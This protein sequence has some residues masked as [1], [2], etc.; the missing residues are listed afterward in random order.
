MYFKK[1]ITFSIYF[2]AIFTIA[3]LIFIL[4]YSFTTRGIYGN[5]EYI[6]TLENYSKIINP[7]YFKI[8][9]RTLLFASSNTLLCI[10]LG[11][12]VAYYISIKKNSKIK[13]IL[14]FLVILPFWSNF[15]IRTY[16]WI[17]LLR[18]EGVINTALISVGIID[19]P[20]NILFN[21]FSVMLGMFYSYIPLAILPMYSSLEKIDNNFIDAAYDLGASHFRTLTKIIIPLSKKGI[22]TSTL[23]V[24]VPSFGEFVIPDILGG[25]KSILLGNIIKDQFI[26]SRNWPLGSA[27]AT[28]IIIIMFLLLPLFKSTYKETILRGS[29]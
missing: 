4:F 6:F 8:F 10:L 17:I 20:L 24:F 1:I 5:I 12:P 11:F 16:A 18:S 29:S 25:S 28:V 13:N 15:L 21:S 23:L 14:L 19:Q 9:L 2:I 27:L 26:S 22:L 7:I 3:P